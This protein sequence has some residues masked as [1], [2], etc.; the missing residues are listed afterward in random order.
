[1]Q[2][3]RGF[4]R[5]SPLYAVASDQ[6]TQKTTTRSQLIGSILLSLLLIGMFILIFWNW[7]AESNGEIATK[8]STLIDTIILVLLL[9]S[10]LIPLL[11]RIYKYFQ[12][13]KSKVLKSSLLHEPEAQQ[14]LCTCKS[15]VQTEELSK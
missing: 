3:A 12:Q 10:L 14:L 4:L 13:R 9:G 5:A 1:M 15:V 6:T 8:R 11:I 2:A 7:S